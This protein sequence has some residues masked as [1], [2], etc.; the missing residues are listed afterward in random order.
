MLRR[1]P[2][3]ML[4]HGAQLPLTHCC[5]RDV[6]GFGPSPCKAT[7]GLCRHGVYQNLVLSTTAVPFPCFPSL[8]DPVPGIEARWK[9]RA[10][11]P[12]A[13][14]AAVPLWF[15]VNNKSELCVQT[16][17]CQAL[18]IGGTRFVLWKW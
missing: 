13:Q 8:L 15:C 9:Q 1:C 14:K 2:R 4:E 18:W 3:V 6:L 10:I 7:P 16:E 11:L 5:S 12:R 17:A